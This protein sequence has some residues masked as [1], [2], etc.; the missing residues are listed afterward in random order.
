MKGCFCEADK[1]DK[2]GDRIPREAGDVAGFASTGRRTKD[3]R[4]A[5]LHAD[6]LHMKLDA[7]VEK[8]FG[9]PIS[10]PHGHA[11]GDDEEVGLVE[12]LRKRLGEG[13]FVIT[14]DAEVGWQAV[15]LLEEGE[16]HGAVGVADFAGRN[17]R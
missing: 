1:T 3:E 14:A 10:R 2:G 6:F 4:F 7:E 15:R 11:S 8:D 13:F 16:E 9:D 17:W 5:G 12:R